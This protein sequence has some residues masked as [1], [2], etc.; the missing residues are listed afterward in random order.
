M[1]QAAGESGAS[2]TDTR[3]LGFALSEGRT[4]EDRIEAGLIGQYD[5]VIAC[6]PEDAA[7]LDHPGVSVVPNGTELP[8]RYVPSLMNRSILFV[9]PFRYPPNLSGIL[10]FL[11]CVYPSLCREIAG[12]DLVVLGGQDA[13]AIAGSH[14]AFRQP[15][16]RVVGHVDDVAPWYE[17]CALTINPVSDIRG[18]SV[19]VLESIAF[20]RVCISTTEGARGFHH[21]KS[22]ALAVVPRIQDFLPLLRDLLLNDER[23]RSL[24]RPSEQVHAAI[25]WRRSAETQAALYRNLLSSGEDG[26]PFS[27]NEFRQV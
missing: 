1:T 21:L 5:A 4:A 26:A 18:S 14:A 15:G 22:A 25:E 20:G 16:V 3:Q 7:L 27:E 24:E 19:K 23:R 11:D 17:K 13:T 6:S 8:S 9:G 12:V 10:S 2:T